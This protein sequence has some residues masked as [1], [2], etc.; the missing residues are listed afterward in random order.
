MS[1][2]AIQCV[3]QELADDWTIFHGDAVSVLA[4]MPED[5]I[6]VA[7]YSPPFVSLFVYSPSIVDM[8]NCQSK[9]E[10]KEHYRFLCDQLFRV[11]KPGRSVLVHCSDIPLKKSVDGELGIYRFSDDIAEIH[12]ASGFITDQRTTIWRCPVVEATRT[13]SVRL[14]Q[15]QIRKDS[16]ISATG[17]PDYLF[18]FRKPG[19]NGNPIK[20]ALDELPI[21]LWREWAS[22]VWMD[23]RQTNVLPGWQDAKTGADER[24]ICPLQLDLIE[25]ALTLWSNKGDVVL[26]PFSGIGSTGNVALKIGRKY[27]GIELKEEYYIQSISNVKLSSDQKSLF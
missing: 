1:K 18:K 5:C 4:Q 24:H 6:D 9:E 12:E 25:R 11:T 22:P 15:K 13:K 7:I 19:I 20:Q 21:E 10:F 8:G 14:L 26:D 3:N 17:M 27:V 16:A 23:I 2:H